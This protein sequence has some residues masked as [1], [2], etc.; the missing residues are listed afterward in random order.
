[1]RTLILAPHLD[2]GVF[3][4]GGT[5]ARLVA[6]G[7]PVQ[8]LTLCAGP[9]PAALSPFAAALH[10]RWGAPAGA[11]A[12]TAAAMVARRR[13]EDR[14]AHALLG[15]ADRSLAVPDCIYRRGPDGRWLYPDEA[16]LFGPVD[17]ADRGVEDT[18][19]AAIA[20]ATAGTGRTRLLAPLAVG[21]HVDHQLA[22]RAAERWAERHAAGHPPLRYY[23]DYPY[24][25]VEAR[26]AQALGDP[27]G[28]RARTVKLSEAHL[29]AKVAAMACYRSQ[30]S[31]FWRDEADMAERVA[32]FARRRGPAGGLGER[33]WER[34]P[35]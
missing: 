9:P 13:A 16:A 32:A 24:I 10:R 25:E 21:R 34:A 7:R 14:A 11:E 12:A 15:A 18:L 29:A 28:W 23:E 8:V 1:M 17:P 6:G 30:I 3:S 22:R 33:L 5:L 19:A 31:S 27:A 20:A 26:L 2:D 35:G 4:V